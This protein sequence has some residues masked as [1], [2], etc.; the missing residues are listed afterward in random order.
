VGSGGR[1][2]RP[3]SRGGYK[4]TY[5]YGFVRLQSGQVFWMIVP[6]LNT[7]LFSLAL[8]E[9]AKE[10]GAGKERRILLVVD[11]T[12]WHTG[13]HRRGDGD[14]RRDAPEVLAQGLSGA[15]ACG[16]EV[17]ANHRGTSQRATSSS[18]SSRLRR[19]WWPVASSYSISPN[20]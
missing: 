2:P 6:T 10:V 13:A 12:G 18:R 19:H 1:D 3:A 5:L 7:E 16:E 4:W 15:G 17:A 9:F 11:K 14:P 20:S 8:R